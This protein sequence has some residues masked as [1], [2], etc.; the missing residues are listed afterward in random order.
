MFNLCKLTVRLP[1]IQISLCQHTSPDCRMDELIIKAQWSDLMRV[2]EIKKCTR[3]V[4]MLEEGMMMA[5]KMGL[6]KKSKEETGQIMILQ[7]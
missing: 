7:H 1:I 6:E 3:E 4:N 2:N 5:K